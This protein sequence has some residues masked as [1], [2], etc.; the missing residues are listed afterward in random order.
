MERL[1]SQFLVGNR[2]EWFYLTDIAMRF[3]LDRKRLDKVLWRVFRK[4]RARV[5]S[6]GRGYLR[7]SCR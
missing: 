6:D 4:G 5:R 2:I 3:D 7:W 1:V